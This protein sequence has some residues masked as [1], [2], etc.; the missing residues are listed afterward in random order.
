M[1]ARFAM[2]PLQAQVDYAQK[3]AGSGGTYTAPKNTGLKASVGYAYA[4]GGQ[5]SVIAMQ[6]KTENVSGTATAD[7]KQTSLGLNWEH[8]I[9]N[10]QLLGQ[11][12]MQRSEEH[13]SELQ[14]H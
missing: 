1:T 6:V 5:I 9:G 3:T 7:Y 12:G 14:S 2:G 10:V 8:M 4:P 13:T 11:Y